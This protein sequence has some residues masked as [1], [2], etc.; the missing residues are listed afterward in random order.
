[1][2]GSH[3]ADGPGARA[4]TVRIF[5]VGD[6]KMIWESAYWKDDLLRSASILKKKRHQKVWRES[7][8][9]LVEKT[10]MTGFYVVRKLM[11]A[12]KLSDAV[13]HHKIP[14]KSHRH[15]GKPVTLMNWDHIDRHYDLDGSREAQRTLAWLS[16]QMIH[17]YVFVVSVGADGGMDGVFFASGKERNKAVHYLHADGII[18]I[19]EAVGGNYPWRAQYRF[20]PDTQDYD[21]HQE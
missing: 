10:V 19:F 20:N 13:I 16:N 11:E 12:R 18:E 8:M 2:T 6:D 1:M 5:I 17:S 15:R 9:A 4:Y 21:V 3:A 14:V 7:S